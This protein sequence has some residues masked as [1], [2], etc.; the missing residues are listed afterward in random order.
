MGKIRKRGA[1]L[2]RSNDAALIM[3]GAAGATLELRKRVRVANFYI[4]NGAVQPCD[5]TVLTN[6]LV[7]TCGVAASQ[8]RNSGGDGDFFEDRFSGFYARSS[9][10]FVA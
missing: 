5:I 9:F 10:E 6:Y 3:S 7:V 2:T 4:F 8:W 1:P